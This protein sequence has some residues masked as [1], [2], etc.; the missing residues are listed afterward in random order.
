MRTFHIIKLD[1]SLIEVKGEWIATSDA[2]AVVS[3][4][5]GALVAVIPHKDVL[6]IAEENEYRLI[7]EAPKK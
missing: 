7:N 5:F 2:T 3:N 1:G 4:C 6:C